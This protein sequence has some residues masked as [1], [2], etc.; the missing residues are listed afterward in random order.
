M[1]TLSVDDPFTLETAVTVELSDEAQGRGV[2]ERSREAFEKFRRTSIEERIALVEKAMQAMEK[3]KD[4]IA[5]DISKMMGK[6]VSQG[7]NEVAGMAGRARHM[8]SIAKES[9]RDV[10]V[11]KDGFDRRIVKEPL[12]VVLDLPAWH[13]PLL[14][15]IN[16]VAPAILAGNSVVVKHSPRSPLCGMHF[17]RA[18]AEAGAPNDLVQALDCDHPTTERLVG[19][20]LVD[21]VVFTGSV[22]GGH[23]IQEAAAKQFLHVGLELGGNDAAYV[24]ADADLAKAVENIVD[25]CIYNAGQS[26]CAV[27]RI[28]V[29]EK[30]YD[31]FVA[32]CEPLVRA[33]VI[34]DPKDDKTTLGPVAQPH[35]VRELEAMVLD[36]KG[37]GARLV[38]GGRSTQVDGKGRFFEAT[39]L[40][41]VAPEA[42]LM[43]QESFGPLVVVAKVS[44]DEEALARMNDSELGLTASVW[45]TDAALA[46]R[47]ARDLDVGTVYMNRC[48]SVDPALPWVGAKSSGRGHS[49]SALGFDQLTRP[50]SLH[51]RLHY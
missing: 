14:T 28:F 40:V 1:A 18:F 8:A 17:A 49:L 2:L 42:R 13:Y 39:L 22:F 3:R 46:E 33:Y 34:G 45:T 26:C 30:L 23:R 41:D 11:P 37:R 9:L 50:K 12:G 21:H 5:L 27:E 43:R 24:A 35:H 31:A 16:V 38:A 32:A 10:V 15:A 44:S 19:S 6:P 47:M 20:G 36:A 7:L 4:E 48:D 25:G 51:F 29:H